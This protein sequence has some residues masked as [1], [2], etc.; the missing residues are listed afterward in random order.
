M[1]KHKVA[2]IVLFIVFALPIP[3]F[4]LSIGTIILVAYALILRKDKRTLHD[5]VAGTIVIK[6][7]V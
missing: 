2:I 4:L 5:I 3:G 1:E 6:A 7:K